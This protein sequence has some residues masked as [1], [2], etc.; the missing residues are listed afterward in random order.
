MAT[1][2]WSLGPP[3][4]T[5]EVKISIQL[6]FFLISQKKFLLGRFG[7]IRQNSAKRSFTLSILE[8][9][10]TDAKLRFALLHT[11]QFLIVEMTSAPCKK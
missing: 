6:L 4:L 5:R 1:I 10:D 3:G 7:R 2:D 11:L 8:T 9:G